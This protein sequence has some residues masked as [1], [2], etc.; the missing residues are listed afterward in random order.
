MF[1]I[2]IDNYTVLGE[3]ISIIMIWLLKYPVFCVGRSTEFAD[4]CIIP[5]SKNWVLLI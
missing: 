3:H 4:M 2:R 5:D 1:R